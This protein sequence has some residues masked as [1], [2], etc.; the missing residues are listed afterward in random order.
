MNK[1]YI[2]QKDDTRVYCI[3]DGSQPIEEELGKVFGLTKGQGLS[4]DLWQ[5]KVVVQ[6]YFRGD[7]LASFPVLEELDTEEEPVYQLTPIQE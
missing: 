6:N 1:K 4:A 7:N 3:V 2:L 5:G